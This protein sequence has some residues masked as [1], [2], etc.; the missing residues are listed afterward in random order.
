MAT[1]KQQGYDSYSGCDIVVTARLA[2]LNNSTKKLE[3]KIYTLG[4]LQTLSVSTHQDKKPVRVI[5]SMNALDYTMGQRTIAGSLVFAVF[6][7]HF[8]TEMFKDLE[9]A[10]GKTFFLPDELPAMDITITFANEYGRTSRMAIYGVRIINEG[11]VMSINDLYTENTYQFVATAMEPLKKG[12]KTGASSNKQNEAQIASVFEL[13]NNPITFTGE[14][15]WNQG[16]IDNNEDLKRVLL[17]VDTEQPLY[18]SQEGIAK[19]TLS[20]TQSTGVIYIANQIQD[21]II[22]EIHIE[23]KTI[24]TAY[25]ESG[26]YSAWFED[27]GQTLSNTVMFSI[28]SIG[29]YNSVYDD[30][31]NIDNVSES[32]ISITCNNPTHTLAVC[33]NAISNEIIELELT[34]RKCTFK[35]LESNT[36]Y[37]IYTRDESTISNVAITKTLS[38]EENFI[39]GFKNYVRCNSTLLSS[40]SDDYEEILDKLVN[41]EDMLQVL[42]KEQDIKAKELIY[43]AIKYK[44][45]FTS[46]L[47]IQKINSMPQKDLNNIYGNSFKFNSGVSKANVFLTKGKKEYYEYSEQYPSE[48]TYIGKSNKTYNV[49]A[50][51]NDF[52]KSPKYTFYS[53]SDNDKSKIEALYGDANKLASIDLTNYMNANKKYSDTALKCLAVSDN[54]NID[55]KLLKA[56]GLILDE[57]CNL[58]A[59][60][61]YNDLLG[62]KDKNYYLVISELNQSLDKTPYRKIKIEDKEETVLANKY[63]TAINNKDIYA[64]WIEDQNFN[65]ISEIGYI[66]LNEEVIN[67]N[68]SVIE[69]EVQ[70]LLNKIEF[71]LGKSNYTIDVYSSVISKTTNLKNMFYDIA[72][73]AIDLKLDNVVNT[74]YELFKIKFNDLYINQDKYRRAIYDNKTKEL[75]FDNA[76]NAQ[77]VHIGFKQGVNYKI[78]VLNNESVVVDNTYDYNL[79]YVIDSNPIIKSGFVLIAENNILSNSIRLEEI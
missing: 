56:P 48:M 77:I 13:E 15:I 46:V 31:P 16:Y 57:E 66:S 41:D 75:K 37:G 58:I 49:I 42:E 23:D 62:E 39:S 11:Q 18:E 32:T 12:T 5:G 47:N 26:M 36:T 2:T 70:K 24:Y 7:Q 20:P 43:M 76:N 79:Y 28:D 59:D 64:I 44:N 61:K 6:D 67:F 72:Q 17:T 69:D 19:F 29:E 21:K 1:W 45:E 22:S 51:S 38:P 55:M 53:Y 30:T 27:K 60:I 3:E 8:A 9:R 50:I 63:L 54:K 33:V 74:I 52:I 68:T 4:S 34:S 14:D 25:L 10:T 40:E 65:I 71:N 73:S 35:S 78:E